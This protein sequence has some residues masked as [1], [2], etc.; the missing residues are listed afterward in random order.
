[1]QV[2]PKGQKSPLEAPIFQ[3]EIADVGPQSKNHTVVHAPVR[4]GLPVTSGL[5]R[6]S[7]RRRVNPPVQGGRTVASGL[8]RQVEPTGQSSATRHR[9]IPLALEEV[10]MVPKSLDCKSRRGSYVRTFYRP[11]AQG[12]STRPG[13]STRPRLRFYWHRTSTTG[14]DS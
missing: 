8:R 7:G 6:Q 12:T 1:M 13:R 5:R 11:L 10:Q 9:P 14:L 2:Q 4:G 3:L